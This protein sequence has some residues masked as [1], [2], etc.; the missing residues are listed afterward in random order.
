MLQREEGWPGVLGVLAAQCVLGLRPEHQL[1]IAARIHG[2]RHGAAA[3]IGYSD[4]Q[5]RRRWDQVKELVLVPLGLPEHDDVLAGIW[6]VLHSDC[7]TAE[8]VSLLRN[9]SRFASETT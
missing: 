7:C 3:L 6:V 1:V 8:A 4:S 2:G 5:V 9:D